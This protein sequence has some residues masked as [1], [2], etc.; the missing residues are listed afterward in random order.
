MAI[1]GKGNISDLAASKPLVVA[2]DFLQDFVFIALLFQLH[3]FF[4]QM[5][6]LR[7]E[8]FGKSIHDLLELF[9]PIPDFFFEAGV[10]NV[11][12]CFAFYPRFLNR[13]LKLEIC[14][15]EEVPNNPG[16]VGMPVS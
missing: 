3:D 1:T 6:E 7:F 14:A 4:I 12:Q 13:A 11:P 10:I 9:I 2:L 16:L 15:S 5:I 8:G